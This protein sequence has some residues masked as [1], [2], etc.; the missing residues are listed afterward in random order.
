[1]LSKSN[2]EAQ[3]KAV[4]RRKKQNSM[5][6]DMIQSKRRGR[7]IQDLSKEHRMSAARQTGTNTNRI[8]KE[9]GR[10]GLLTVGSIHQWAENC[11]REHSR[12][13]CLGHQG[14]EEKI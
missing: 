2:Q 8:K 14:S 11:R 7:V 12:R 13:S 6:G 3:N 10:K 1:M 9:T 5:Q 4:D